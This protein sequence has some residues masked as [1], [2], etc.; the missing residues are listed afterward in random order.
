MTKKFKHPCRFLWLALLAVIFGCG[1]QHPDK[2]TLAFKQ[3]QADVYLNY[4]T[5]YPDSAGLRLI[6]AGKLD[7]VGRYREALAQMDTLI[8]A[9]S[10]KYGFW[11]VRAAIQLDSTDTISAQQSLTRAIKLYPGQEAM[12]SQAE[13][14]AWQ[15]KD[16]CLKLAAAM[17]SSSVHKDYIAGLYASRM[18]DTAKATTLLQRCTME[19]PQFAKAY[20][21]LANLWDTLDE[22]QSALAE[23]QRGLRVS[24][25]Y[26]ALL[27]LGG[28]LYEKTGK[29]DSAAVLYKRSLSIHPYQPSL[30]EKV[31][32]N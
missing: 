28:K 15:K 23:V 9:D 6:V 27:N 12:L 13:I 22:Q 2:G 26:L 31:S 14:Y 18:M 4:L 7:S 32:S 25:D 1:Q 16:T 19:D 30:K 8:A 10:I 5:Q 21:A 29:P 3:K 20:V 24:P 11:V 17:T